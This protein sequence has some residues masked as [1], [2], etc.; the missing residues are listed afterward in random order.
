MRQYIITRTTEAVEG[1][2]VA[3]TNGALILYNDE[4]LK[5]V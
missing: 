4:N 5:G 3:K 1:L 2:N